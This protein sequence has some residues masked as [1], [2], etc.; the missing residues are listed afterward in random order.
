MRCC[1]GQFWRIQKN[2]SL[3]QA[4]STDANPPIQTAS[5]DDNDIQLRG[6]VNGTQE[7][8]TVEQCKFKDAVAHHQTKHTRRGKKTHLQH[9]QAHIVS[10]LRVSRTYTPSG[11]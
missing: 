3:N 7:Q 10:T 8:E 1:V 11:K 2:T 6:L 5:G 4:P 9:H